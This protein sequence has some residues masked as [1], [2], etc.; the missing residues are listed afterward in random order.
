MKKVLFLTKCK[1]PYGDASAKRYD[2]FKR[3]FLDNNYEITIIGM[4]ALPYKKNVDVDGCNAVS[5]KKYS[6]PNYLQKILNH[7]FINKRILRYVIKNHNDADVILADPRFYKLMQKKH[8][9]FKTNNLIYSIVEF[10]SPSEYR[11]N[12]LFSKSYKENVYINTHLNPFDGKVIAI[13]SYLENNFANRGVKVVRIPFV[14]D[15]K[16]KTFKLTTQG[17]RK[18]IYCGNPRA[19]DKLADMLLSFLLLPKDLI[20]NC[21]VNIYGVNKEWLMKQRISKA[22]KARILSFTTFHGYVKHTE[23]KRLYQQND[24]SLLLRPENERY[25]KAGFPTKITESLEYG[26]PPVT[27]F[28]SDLKLYLEDNFNCIKSENDTI[29][30]FAKSLERAITKSDEEINILKSNSKKTCVEKLDIRCFYDLMKE[31]IE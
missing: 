4:G 24:Y 1:Y 18:F 31:I 12:G 2:V 19:K 6:K 26:I 9:R 5:L 3:Y 23:M 15:N 14:V 20:N 29:D 27:N 30:S 17:K 21:E 8:N 16:E 7:L 25:A 10:Y 28:T 11:F 13:S 22:D